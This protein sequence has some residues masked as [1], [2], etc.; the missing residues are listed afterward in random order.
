MPALQWLYWLTF[1]LCC[2]AAQRADLTRQLVQE[3]GSNS[4]ISGTS[5]EAGHTFSSRGPGSFLTCGA[6][7][8]FK[9]S[10][11]G[12][13]ASTADARA[14]SA[15]CDLGTFARCCLAPLMAPLLGAASG[16]PASMAFLLTREARPFAFC[17]EASAA[18]CVR[19]LGFFVA[20]P[21]G[22]TGTAGAARKP[23]EL[24]A[25]SGEQSEYSHVQSPG[26]GDK[27]V[28]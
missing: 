25:E 12:V 10:S 17:W 8:G 19:F 15:G 11:C 28:R 24:T 6:G 7:R 4:V 27:S 26:V 16:M 21:T 9:S 22:C 3:V 14:W 2:A 20:G 23:S 5:M 13:D 18:R 1:G